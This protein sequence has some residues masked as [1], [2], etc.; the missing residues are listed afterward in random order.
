MHLNSLRVP[1]LAFL[2]LGT[3]LA[4]AYC[5]ANPGAKQAT[6]APGSGGKGGQSA[7]DTQF[8]GLPTFLLLVPGG[9]VEMGLEAAPFLAAAS[10]VVVPAKPETAA[11]ISPT[12]LA[13]A[14]RRSASILGHRK[15]EVAPFLLG[16]YPVK[17]SEYEP[18]VASRRKAG[19]KMRPPFHWWRFGRADSYN[20]KLADINKLFPKMKD[21]PVQ[22]W[23]RHGDELPYKVEDEKGRPIGDQPVTYISWREANEFAGWLG[24]RLPTEAEWTRAARGDGKNVWPTAK[25]EDPSTDKFS[26]QL[27]KDLQI[28]NSRDQ[29]GKPVGTV[30]AAKG[31]FGHLDMFGQVWQF[32]G[33]LGFHPISGPELFAAEWKALQKDKSGQLLTA[34]PAW[35]DDKAIAKGGSFLSAGEPIQLLVDAR[36]PVLTIDVMESLGFRLAK[37]LK[38]GYDA[39]FSALR[40]T[41][42]RSPF[43]IDQ[44]VDLTGQVGAERYELDASGFPSAYDTVSLAPV[45]WLSKDKGAELGKL[46]EKSHVAP[47]LVGTLMTTD[48]MLQP[49]APAGIYSVLYRKAGAPRE[50]VD[51]IKQGHKELA[52]GAKAKPATDKPEDAEKDKEKDKKDKDKDKRGWREVI[53]SFGITEKDVEGKD[54]ADGNLKFVRI[55]GVEIPTD[56][57]CFLLHGGSDGKVVAAWRATNA[58]PSSVNAFPPTLAL[59]AGE[60]NKAVA[61]IHFGVPISQANGKRVAD[62]HVHVTLDRD[63]PGVDKPWRLPAK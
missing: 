4:T 52:A 59:E 3:L 32:V 62:F 24:M 16:R 2:F 63:A 36:A 39:I 56:E 11:K 31:P 19:A 33:E 57:D 20:E 1:L 58:K 12:K 55:D 18:Y 29:A 50:L 5:Q 30:Q 26:D 28:F 34:P 53:A 46:I 14:M 44:D 54:A 17:N 27:L 23:E 21:G 38:P 8:A 10:Q 15:V 40:G 48:A 42:N 43:A 6:L 45:N 7:D 60:K 22:F 25:P 49:A 35:K 41:Y 47:L 13:E 37:S 51:A 61:K 9:T